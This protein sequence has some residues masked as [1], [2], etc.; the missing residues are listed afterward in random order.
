MIEAKISRRYSQ[1]KRG[2]TKRKCKMVSEYFLPIPAHPTKHN[3]HNEQ[4]GEPD[5]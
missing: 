3:H 2:L 4:K 5:C 1:D